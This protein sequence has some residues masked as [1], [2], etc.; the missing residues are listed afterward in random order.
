MS[1]TGSAFARTAKSQR[2]CTRIA[3]VRQGSISAAATMAGRSF[4]LI[5]DGMREMAD[6]IRAAAQADVLRTGEIMANPN[7]YPELF[8]AY[9]D[10]RTMEVY[11]SGSGE[12]DQMAIESVRK[13]TSGPVLEVNEM[14]MVDL[15]NVQN[16]ANAV[17]RRLGR[18]LR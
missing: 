14:A 1:L 12:D 5:R 18:I 9:E 10:A 8:E 16:D 4:A 15:E 6:G 17:L 13:R 11:P 2:P 7:N 3:W